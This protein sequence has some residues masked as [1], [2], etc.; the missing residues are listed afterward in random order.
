M[1][2]V[3][4]AAPPPPLSLYVHWPFCARICP[5]CDFNVVRRRGPSAIEDDLADAILADMAAQAAMTGPRS[6]ATLFLGGGTPSLMQPAQAARIID[7]ARRLWPPTG[8]VEI[9]LEANPADA[10]AGRFTAFAEAGVAR[11]S[12]GLQSL[13]DAE[14]G[15]LGRDHDAAQARRAALL[16]MRVFPRVSLDLIHG[17]PGQTPE[18]WRRAIG[19]VVA[20][21][22]EHISAYELTVEAG[23]ALHR[24]VSRGSIEL[25]GEEARA[26]LFETTREAL[27]AAGFEAYEVSNYAR[28]P[29][30]RSRH[31][32]AYWRGGDYAAVGP[33]AHGRLIL[34]QGRIA[35]E[36]PRR[37]ADYIASVAAGEGTPFEVLSARD[38]ALERL[39][40]GLRTLEGVALSELTPLGIDAG[41]LAPL[42]GFIETRDGRLYATPHGR[43]LLDTLIARLAG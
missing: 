15:L 6:L 14:L 5:Y 20:F 26:A 17:L 27:A 41:R 13:D 16:A 31:N 8:E 23:T 32:L 39:M 18:G 30:A 42:G 3:P 10:E 40:M 1:S 7:A 36:R 9:S 12:L 4:P 11:L 29:A 24:A 19:E 21:G 2:P 43:P 35:Y 37:I 28:F 33:G 22:S 38:A 25:P 34:G